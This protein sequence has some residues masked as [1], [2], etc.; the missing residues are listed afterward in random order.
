MP[1]TPA[2]HKLALCAALLGSSLMV[3]ANPAPPPNSDMDAPLFYQLLVGEMELRYKLNEASVLAL[4]ATVLGA[5][6]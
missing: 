1:K 4:R 6:A 2:L 3:R 5:T